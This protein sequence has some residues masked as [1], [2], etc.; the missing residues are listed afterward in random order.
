M[1]LISKRDNC[2]PE[3]SKVSKDIIP[4]YCTEFSPSFKKTIASIKIMFEGLQTESQ[5]KV[6]KYQSYSNGPCAV[7]FYVTAEKSQS[8]RL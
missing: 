1:L 6:N 7:I 2:F 3:R 5:M 8:R 4:L